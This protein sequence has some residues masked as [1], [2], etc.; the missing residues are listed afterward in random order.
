MQATIFFAIG[1]MKKIYSMITFKDW[2]QRP[3]Q[4][5]CTYLPSQ[6]NSK[7]W[8]ELFLIH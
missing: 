8:M 5:I 2:S 4:L 6:D 1:N 7:I 3:K